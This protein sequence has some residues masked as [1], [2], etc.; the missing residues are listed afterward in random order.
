M[1]RFKIIAFTHK[2]TD[3]KDLSRCFIE[4][5]CVKD[6]LSGIKKALKIDEIFYIGTCN[7]VEFLFITAQ[8]VT[9]T[10]LHTFFKNLNSR[11]SDEDSTWADLNSHIFEGEDALRHLFNVTSSLDSLVV[12]EREIITQVRKSYDLCYTNG[13]TGDL[14][15]IIMQ[16]TV[17]TAKEIFTH[18]QIAQNPISV[19]SLAY[20]KLRELNVKLDARFLIVGAGQTNG[21]MA[22][23]LLK[24]GFKNF[25]VFNRTLT[26]AEVLAQEL[27]GTAFALAD[28]SG[29]DQGFDVLLSC[30][31]SAEP[32]IT[33]EIYTRL[34]KG[35]TSKKVIID[36]A[37]PCDVD[38]EVLKQNN[39]YLIEVSGLKKIAQENIAERE[40][41][42]EVAEK[43]VTQNIEE[44][45]LIYKTR[46]VELAMQD[47][48]RKIKEIKNT[49]VNSVFAKDIELLDD[50]SKEVLEKILSYM[51][52]KYISVPM[53]LA[54]D[55]LIG[56]E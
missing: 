28:L 25:T 21:T 27:N 45:K 19:V 26:H 5:D 46:C 31:G 34:L 55:I 17:K 1:N 4:E 41:E 51:E 24:H 6:R 53:I 35:D 29:Y 43:I 49:A 42:L 12:G 32:I 54:K 18:T 37:I 36:L 16:S 48:P 13:L 9:K 7:R 56:K 15:R 20:R 33:P 40:K 22:K 3:L 23:Y 10:F 47:V 52:K 39:T 14:L 30:T 2:S 44:F 8:P 50:N 38:P 11:W